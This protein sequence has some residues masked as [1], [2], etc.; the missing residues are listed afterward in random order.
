METFMRARGYKPF[1]TN[2]EQ[3]ALLDR[4]IAEAKSG[5]VGVFDLDGCLF[6]TRIRLVTIFHEF[7]SVK[8]VV[9]RYF[10]FAERSDFTDWDL[11]KPL[12]KYGMPEPEIDAIFKEFIEFWHVRFFSDEYVAWDDPMPGAT[13]LV[14]A[15]YDKGMQIVYL[16]GRDIKMRKGTEQALRRCGFPYDMERVVLFTKPEFRMEDTTYKM[17]A[18]EEIE[19]LGTI[20]VSI[21]NEPANINSMTDRFPDALCVHIETDHSFREDRPYKH[22]PRLRSFYRTTWPLAEESDFLK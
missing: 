17:E 11:K 19:Q 16:T 5:T 21:D 2:L 6:D 14:Q 8:G 4:I 12:R 20:A 15:C 22:I 7:A 9:G 1:G 10:S 3:D 18:L 13:D